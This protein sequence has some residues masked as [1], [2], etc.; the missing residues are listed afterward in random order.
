MPTK[1]GLEEDISFDM[2]PMIDVVF[3]LIIF[4]MLVNQMVQVERAELKLPVASQAQQR[5]EADNDRLIINIHK[6][7]RIEVAGRV[8]EDKELTKL[9]FHEAK[10]S[11]NSEGQV[12]RAITIRGDINTPYQ[13][14]QKIM[15][16]CANQNIYKISIGAKIPAKV[17]AKN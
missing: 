1:K 5:R 12:G 8:V 6:N 9:L 4:F 11:E 10:M 17:P 16:K 13:H 14:I 2:T 7:G 15:L 3:N